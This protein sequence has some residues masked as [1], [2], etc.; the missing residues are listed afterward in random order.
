MEEKNYGAQIVVLDRGWVYY[1][2]EVKEEGDNLVLR[3]AQCIRAWG[4]TKGLGELV[5]GPTKST[6]L[7][8]AGT[9]VAPKRALIH[10]IKCNPWN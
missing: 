2:P 5:S 4:T 8:P 7:D 6:K 9:I 3:D 10:L 1:S